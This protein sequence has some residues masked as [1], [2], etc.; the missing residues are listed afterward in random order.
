M[1]LADPAA[2]AARSSEL[3]SRFIACALAISPRLPGVG[4]LRRMCRNLRRECLAVRRLLQRF[5]RDSHALRISGGG[6]KL[7]DLR[8]LRVGHGERAGR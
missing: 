8:L 3:L 1:Q 4:E 7:F 6:Q 2:Q 5:H